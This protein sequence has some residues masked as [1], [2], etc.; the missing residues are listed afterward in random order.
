LVVPSGNEV[1]EGG[2]QVTWEPGQLSTTV[3]AAKLTIGEHWPGEAVTDKLGGHTIV[4]GCTSFTVTVNEQVAVAPPA[5]LARQL[6]VVVP[7]ANCEPAGG[8]HSTPAPVQLSKTKG[9]T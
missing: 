9:V 8:E 1:P 5:S 7:I 3:G 4:I 2:T 6:T